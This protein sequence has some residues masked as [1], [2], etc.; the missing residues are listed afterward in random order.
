[1]NST[2]VYREEYAITPEPETSS[3]YPF[4]AVAPPI[5]M[6]STD[7][8]LVASAPLIIMGTQDTAIAVV[9]AG[10]CLIIICMIAVIVCVYARRRMKKR[11]IGHSMTMAIADLQD[12]SIENPMYGGMCTE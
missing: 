3:D 10:L 1:M 2:G 6:M 5:M 9:I 7:P 11:V 12:N 4:T 8:H